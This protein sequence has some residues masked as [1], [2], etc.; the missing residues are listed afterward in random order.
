MGV[1]AT[2]VRGC[3]QH[4]DDG[5]AHLLAKIA[6]V[7]LPSAVNPVPCS[8]PTPDTYKALLREMD[9]ISKAP[10]PPKSPVAAAEEAWDEISRA[11]VG[12]MC[13]ERID[14]LFFIAKEMFLAALPHRALGPAV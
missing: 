7:E 12:A 4:M 5:M 14:L 1:F 2:F 13:P 9:D 3:G 6:G 8:L 11:P 10:N